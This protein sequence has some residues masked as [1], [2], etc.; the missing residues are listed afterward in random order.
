PPF[1]KR[2]EGPTGGS[3][4]RKGREEL[5]VRGGGQMWAREGD[6]HTILEQ[7]LIHLLGLPSDDS[8]F[9]QAVKMYVESKDDPMGKD[10][11]IFENLAKRLG[12]PFNYASQPIKRERRRRKDDDDDG[13]DD[14]ITI[15][16]SKR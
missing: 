7:S 14:E 8:R 12:I 5:G 3:L 16:S 9:K 15:R 6:K 2:W 4:R 1:P 13:D 10:F 11:G